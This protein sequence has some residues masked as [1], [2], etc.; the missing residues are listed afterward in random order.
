MDC[1]LVLP[2][3]SVQPEQTPSVLQSWPQR[4]GTGWR[5]TAVPPGGTWGKLETALR[6]AHPSVDRTVVVSEFNPAM[7]GHRRRM[8]TAPGSSQQVLSGT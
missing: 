1:D 6:L 2:I 8:V 7:Y 3:Q 4:V 5:Q